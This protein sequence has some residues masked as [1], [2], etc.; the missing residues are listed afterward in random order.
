L[1]CRRHYPGS[2][3]E[4][5]V[6]ASRVPLC[7]PCTAESESLRLAQE[8]EKLRK[9]K[10]EPPKKKRKTE[11]SWNEEEGEEE[12]SGEGMYGYGNLWKGKAIIKPDI[13]FF[14]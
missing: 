7:P 5:D 11:D 1:T 13:V 3:I 12:E 8:A 9:E 6:F 2:Y 14:G 4:S 10:E